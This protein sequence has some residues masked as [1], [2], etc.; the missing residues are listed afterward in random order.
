M[1]PPTVGIA[2]DS[3]LHEGEVG[4]ILFSNNAIVCLSYWLNQLIASVDERYI[5]YIFS[6]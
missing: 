4:G 1:R 3:T 6:V 5:R 2:T